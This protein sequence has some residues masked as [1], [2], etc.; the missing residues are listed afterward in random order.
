MKTVYFAIAVACLAACEPA[1]PDSGAGVG[2]GD[3]NT[4]EANRLNREAQL[5]GRPAAT[6]VAAKPQTVQPEGATVPTPTNASLSAIPEANT[7]AVSTNDLAAAGIGA[8]TPTSPAV[9]GTASNIEGGAGRVEASPANA[10]PSLVQNRGGISDEQD[11]SAVIDRRGIE[12]DA[13]QRAQNAAQYQVI[14]PTALPQRDGGGAPNIVQYALSTTNNVGQQQFSRSRFNGQRKFQRNCLKYASP[15]QAQ[16][17]FLVRGGP[18]KDRLG[19]DPDG[20]GF[21]CGWDPRP[22]RS[23]LSN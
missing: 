15:D 9:A 14:Q 10:A 13:E 17:D 3:Y 7:G 8:T 20:D 2:F 5:Q 6:V 16:Q 23:G 1:V 4:Y 11:F 12:L 19:I 21:A 18:Q 22:F